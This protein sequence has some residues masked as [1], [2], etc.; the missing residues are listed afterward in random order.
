MRIDEELY[1][2]EG[3]YT[4][5]DGSET[6]LIGR[7]TT[8]CLLHRAHIPP[9]TVEKNGPPGGHGNVQSREVAFQAVDMITSTID[10]LR[11]H[12]ELRFAPAF[13]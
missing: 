2:E 3:L 10:N 11:E 4:W 6:I 7:S 9:H 12:N 1:I 8:S 13:T 5:P